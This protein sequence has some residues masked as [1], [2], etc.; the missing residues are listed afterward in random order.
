MERNIEITSYTQEADWAISLTEAKNHLNILDASFDDLIKVYI[1]SAHSM[2]YSETAYLISGTANVYM[3]SF[4]SFK[5][6]LQ[7]ADSVVVK[8]LDVSGNQQTLSTSNYVLNVNSYLNIEF[9]GSLPT[10][11]G[12][13]SN[14]VT[15][16]VTTKPYSQIGNPMIKQCLLFMVADMFEVRQ[17][18][19]SGTSTASYSRATKNAL[20]LISRRAS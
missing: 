20:R 11:Y 10:L 18:D 3:G 15:V 6:E 17:E 8:Y 4:K 1:A 13:D 9:I 5:C 12:S 7:K 2:L 16:E 14:P 19:I